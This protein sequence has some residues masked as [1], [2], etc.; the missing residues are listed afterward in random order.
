MIQCIGAAA[1]T[2]VTCRLVKV[3]LSLTQLDKTQATAPA[4]APT[5]P[6]APTGLTAAAP[7]PAATQA[8]GAGKKRKVGHGRQCYSMHWGCRGDLCYMSFC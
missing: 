1:G 6:T 8:D 2:Y 5:A 7:V 4:G 3:V